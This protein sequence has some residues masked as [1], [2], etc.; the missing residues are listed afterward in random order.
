M[1]KQYVPSQGDIVLLQFS[2]QRGREQAGMRPALVLT[3]G[4]YNERV[5]LMIACPITSNAK[6]YPFEVP[7]PKG[8]RTHGVILADHVKSLDWRERNAKYVERAPGSTL[9]HVLDKLGLLFQ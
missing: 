3:P 5:G 1:V 6:G 2:P 8:L 7:L 9:Q 4:K